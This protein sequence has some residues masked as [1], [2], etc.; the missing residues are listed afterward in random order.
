MADLNEAGSTN[1]V[2]S[3][4]MN[5]VEQALTRAVREAMILHKKLGYPMVVGRDGQIMWIQPEDIPVS[6]D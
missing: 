4:D 5:L 1:G 6:V 2:Q 3:V